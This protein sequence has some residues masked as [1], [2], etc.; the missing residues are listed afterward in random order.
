[1]IRRSWLPTSL[2]C[3]ACAVGSPLVDDS[4]LIDGVG[5]LQCNAPPACEPLRWTAAS[6]AE[7]QPLELESCAD[8]AR[9]TPEGA[10]SD[11]PATESAAACRSELVRSL[12]L[13]AMCSRA[14]LHA[15]ADLESLDYE[16]ASWSRFELSVEAQAPL[17]IG[18]RR[19]ELRAVRVRLK[20][21]VTLQLE[22]ARMEDVR[23]D[24][25]RSAHGAPQLALVRSDAQQLRL[26]QPQQPFDGSVTM[27]GCTLEQLELYVSEL[28][29]ESVHF[30]RGVLQADSL[31][32]SDAGFVELDVSSQR[33]VL[34]AFETE[35]CRFRLCNYASLI[36]G[37]LNRSNLVSCDGTSVR[38]YGSI[39]TS[40]ALDGTFET[41]DSDFENTILGA[42]ART[43]ILAFQS[44]F[45]SD[46][47]CDG[48]ELLALDA[49]STV[50]CSGCQSSFQ[51]GG[52]SCELPGAG[53]D[54]ASPVAANYCPA[55]VAKRHLP[56]C[57]PDLPPRMRKH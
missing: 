48:L 29:A 3:A 47:L 34:A 2:L 32:A 27:R 13:V 41:D 30:D 12:P 6:L 35:H 26:G 38:L 54:A 36:D 20:G 23:I 43:Q 8:D 57:D 17:T 28:T 16:G 39:I 11:D 14:T 56:Q 51:D 19:P 37:M 4:L 49:T 46:A 21:P 42:G 22:D 44:R 52:R 9:C 24:A 50:K 1:M 45:S 15:P 40:G 31:R 25:E 53:P 33:S 10:S 5:G 7:A 18:L 55:L